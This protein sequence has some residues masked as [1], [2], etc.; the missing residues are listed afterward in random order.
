VAKILLIDDDLMLGNAL[1][2]WFTEAGHILEHA[3]NGQDGWQLLNNFEYDVVLLDWMLGDTT[4]P[5]LCKRFRSQGGKTRVIFLTGQG[6]VADIETGLDVGAD[7]YLV[8]PFDVRVLAARIRSVQRRP[9][10]LLSNELS[11]DNLVLDPVTQTLTIDGIRQQLTSKE[12]GLLE[13][14]LRHPNRP[15]HADELLKA[16]WPSDGGGSVET[17]RTWMK[18]LR[19]KLAAGG[20]ENLIKTVPGLG[21]LIER[22]D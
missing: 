19:K 1:K 9:V 16:V 22:T 15:S 2:D 7:D 3:T 21:Y 13:F 18:N 5:E 17:V 6:D 14:L 8:K 11:I 12:S 10:S 4:G 20:K